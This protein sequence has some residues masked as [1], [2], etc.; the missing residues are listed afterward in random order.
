VKEEDSSQIIDRS[1][2]R[3]ER[4]RVRKD[5]Q[6][7]EPEAVTGLYFDGRKDRTKMQVKKGTK[8]YPVTGMEEH[9]TVV[10]EPDSK[11]V[12]HFSP[13]A[14]DSK[15]IARGMTYLLQR[16]GIATDTILAIG[17]DGTNVNTGVKSSVI[18]LLELKLGR[19]LQWLI[20]LLHANEL[21]L[22]HLLQKLDGVTR[23]PTSFSGPIGK[24]IQACE[25]MPVVAFSPISL[26]AR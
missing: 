17:C 15:S 6:T 12:G 13:L 24:A 5:L 23:G 21:P 8:Y 11:Y 18:R 26:S 3:R 10:S 2:I 19:P 16:K 25:N 4:K 20:C 1:K 9:V 14:G 7:S 22:R